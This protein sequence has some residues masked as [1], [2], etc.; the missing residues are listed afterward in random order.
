MR[1]LF[2]CRTGHRWTPYRD[3]ATELTAD[4]FRVHFGRTCLRCGKPDGYAVRDDLE[5]CREDCGRVRATF[6]DHS[7]VACSFFRVAKIRN[8]PTAGRDLVVR[9]TEEQLAQ[10]RADPTEQVLLDLTRP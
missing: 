3:P 7:V 9:I 10:L 5:R 6:G 8:W 4:G 1:G 2:Q